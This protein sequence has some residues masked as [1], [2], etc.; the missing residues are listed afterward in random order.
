MKSIELRTEDIVA[1]YGIIS[2]ARY[3]KLSDEDKVKVWKI[4][5]KLCPIAEKYKAD[6]EDAKQKFMPSTSFPEELQVAVQYENL[7]EAGKENLPISEEE[8][9]KTLAKW[10]S[11]NSIVNRALKELADQKVEIEMEPVTEDAFGKLMA[12]ND[13]SF[14]QVNKLEFI[15]E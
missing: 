15:L 1:V 12:S 5:R 8:Y 7:K 3:Q 11:Y 13:W 9:K 4:S 10:N 6:I 2:T 14:E